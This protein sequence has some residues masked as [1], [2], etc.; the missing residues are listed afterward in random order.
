MIQCDDRLSISALKRDPQSKTQL[1]LRINY[2]SAM[3][4]VRDK[5]GK[6]KINRYFKKIDENKYCNID[7]ATYQTL[8]DTEKEN[9]HGAGE[10]KIILTDGSIFRQR[11]NNFYLDILDLSFNESKVLESRY[12]LALDSMIELV[13]RDIIEYKPKI[14]NP[15]LKNLTES[16]RQIILRRFYLSQ[17]E[18]NLIF[19]LEYSKIIL[20]EL[21]QNDK[22][23]R[24]GQPDKF[25]TFY[26][27]RGK[28]GATSVKFYDMGYHIPEMEG[29]L[30]VE[31][32]LGKVAFNRLNINIQSLTKQENCLEVIR[33][34]IM[35]ESLKLPFTP[36]IQLKI[37]DAMLKTDN[38]LARMVVQNSRDIAANS[39]AIRELQR[40]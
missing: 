37:A 14:D 36:D 17:Y 15:N 13:D 27:K 18:Y 9:F 3:E 26:T 39:K 33:S 19:P 7:K 30:K 21:S 22:I 23:Y 11:D 20:D 40:R 32:T 1:P 6:I 28:K 38:V 16:M 4:R 5:N 10:N 25:Q 35:R 24:E 12:R 8:S 31:I 29:R 34:E 2:K